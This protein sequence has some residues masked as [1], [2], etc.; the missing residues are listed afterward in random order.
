[1][2]D[3]LIGQQKRPAFPSDLLHL[4]YNTRWMGPFTL[5]ERKQH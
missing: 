3:Q 2:D 5:Q 1:M 4:K